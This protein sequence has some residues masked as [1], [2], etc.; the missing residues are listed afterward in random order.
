[1]AVLDATRAGLELRERLCER[2]GGP[3]GGAEGADFAEL[4]GTDAA[5]AWLVA[6]SA[7]VARGLVSP[8]ELAE[9]R[10]FLLTEEVSAVDALSWARVLFELGREDEGDEVLAATWLAT[11]GVAGIAQ[12]AA[13]AEHP[14]SL[15]CG[16]RPP[17]ID[18]HPVALPTRLG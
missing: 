4:D 17:M 10:V 1:M 5:L 11:C 3:T 13:R 8:V 15:A 18:D 9:A 7:L 16:N 14:P 6:Q 2:A 12:A